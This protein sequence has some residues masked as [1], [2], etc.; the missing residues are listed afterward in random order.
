MR[1]VLAG[2]PSVAVALVRPKLHLCHGNFVLCCLPMRPMKARQC[3]D[4]SSGD[5]GKTSIAM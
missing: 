4:Y 3:K 1:I 2:N 5:K